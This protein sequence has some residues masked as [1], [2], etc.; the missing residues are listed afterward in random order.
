MQFQGKK[1][2]AELHKLRDR[3]ASI[4]YRLNILKPGDESVE[5]LT[6]LKE[7]A[8][9]WKENKPQFD[10]KG[11]TSDE[12]GKLK[13]VTTYIKY[14]ERLIADKELRET[15]FDWILGKGNTV[16]P[17]V[18]FPATVKKINN[19]LLG[20]RIGFHGGTALKVEEEKGKILTLPFE[21]RR[22]NILDPKK[23]VTFKSGYKVSMKEVFEIFKNRLYEVGDLEFLQGGI[24]H[25]N[26]QKWAIDL[27]A[28]RWW[29]QLPAIETIS[30][31]EV[32]ERY[33]VSCNGE[34]WIFNVRASREKPSLDI[35]G[36]HS[37][38]EFAIPNENGYQVY[39]I[40]KFTDGFPRNFWQELNVLT[41]VY[42]AVLLY[43]DENIF[44]LHRQH[45]G[46]AAVATEKEAKAVMQ[47]ILEDILNA[48][49]G[50]FKFQFITEN[51]SHWVW[52]LLHQ[53]LK[54]ARI[55]N[56]FGMS[57]IEVE[58]T[59]IVGKFFQFIRILPTRLC[60]IVLYLF[61]FLIG[62]WR[63]STVTKKNGEMRKI[64]VLATPPWN[65]GEELF[66]PPR[67]FESKASL[68]K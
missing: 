42:D 61:F 22:I 65:R 5:I 10:E 31:A 6:A 39:Y 11:L 51:C 15:F 58:S 23:E 3:I 64:G 52:N 54:E 12:L 32:K 18:E 29:E 34:D 53:H 14:S 48:Q 63:S 4:S 26:P 57:F 50:N 16:R 28:E 24:C 40:G 25:W 30:F 27:E 43:P 2:D 38:L 41:N 44:N 67:L 60:V 56:L 36:T 45:A 21:G 20:G 55:P 62:G 37:F 19:C 7:E 59:G 1:I 17:I 9:A 46:H 13:E 49:K 8:L 33:G 35:V 66:H 68:K 47:S